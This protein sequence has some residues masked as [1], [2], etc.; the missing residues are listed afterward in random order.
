MAAE[1]P[2]LTTEFVT[3][4]IVVRLVCAWGCMTLA[5]RKGRN[6][7]GWFIAGLI[8]EILALAFILLLPDLRRLRAERE[9]MMAE[10]QRLQEELERERGRVEQLRHD[11]EGREETPAKAFKEAT[12]PSGPERTEWFYELRGET[13]GP[14]T[15]EE[16]VSLAR[17]GRIARPTL[18]WSAES[19][20]WSRAEEVEALRAALEGSA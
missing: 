5:A 18:V 20:E 14:H 19:G 9:W 15:E 6:K 11:V 4:M 10:R 7:L 13:F 8:L 17:G 3:L 2:K 16:M 12:I 1:L